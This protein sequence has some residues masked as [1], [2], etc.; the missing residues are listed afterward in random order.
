[1]GISRFAFT[2]LFPLMQLELSFTDQF[3]GYL[4]S[5]NYFGYLLGA[6]FAG[7]Y[8]W[9]SNRVR[10]L[11][12]FLTINIFSILAQGL[13]INYGHWYFLRFIAGLTAGLVFVLISSIT[14]DFLARNH[15]HSWSGYLYS[16][17]GTGI[18]LSGV[19]VPF[20]HYFVGWQGAWMGLGFLSIILG[21][22]VY[23]WVDDDKKQIP[24]LKNQSKSE[25]NTTLKSQ[26]ITFP[27]LTV[28]YAAE[29]M[30]YIISATFL[31]TILNSLPGFDSSSSAFSWAFVGLAAAPSAIIWV[32]LGQKSG[33]INMLILAF[34]IQI[35][36]VSFPLISP[37]V[38]GGLIGAFLFGG[39]FMGITT[40]TMQIAREMYPQQSSKI[41]GYLTFAYGVGQIISPLIAGIL[42]KDTGQYEAAIFF[43]SVVLVIGIMALFIGS[44]K[45]VLLGFENKIREEEI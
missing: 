39:T 31:V 19:L 40:L 25:I 28:A 42:T 29:G 1:M 10:P 5:T 20:L 26:N 4:A 17:V 6:L 13:T 2:P 15:L 27:W 45:N 3:A 36:G 32:K 37:N 22:L 9:P 30:G 44:R 7:F 24:N 12:I 23:L 21:T 18:F 38:F 14:M 33:K 11:T 8:N 16:G 35:I 41:I 34:M 43:A